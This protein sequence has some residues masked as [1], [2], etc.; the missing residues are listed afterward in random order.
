MATSPAID[1]SRLPPPQIID[2]PDFE[3]RFDAKLARLIELVPEFTALVESDPAFK[4]IEADSYDEMALVQ[5]FVEGATQ[6]LLAYARGS[7]L[8]NLAAL[9]GLTRQE[10]T[11]A[12]P[13]TGAPAVME[14]DAD[15]R[16]RTLLAPH[17]YSVAGPERAYVGFARNANPD[18]LD[19]S[20]VSP[21]PTEVVVSVLSRTG[22]GTAPP[23]TLAAVT[24]AL[25]DD[26]RPMTDLVTVQSAE[27]INYDIVANLYRYAGPDPQ[28]LLDTAEASLNAYLES[29][30]RLGRDVP[31]S[32]L[33]AALHVGGIQRVE[34]PS[35]AADVVL[36][37]MQA[38]YPLTITINDA[39]IAD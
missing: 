25:D 9:Y 2:Q 29:A 20:A 35:P 31:R 14:S 4:L 7:N 12:N 30:R 10:I 32:A 19:A 15:L 5:A 24:A 33:I 18:V 3:T 16:E 13:L 21:A 8:D 38:G 11:P 17:T 26:V 6:N 36:T 28:L 39:G 34:L 22:D 27:I 23:A 37:A 1:L